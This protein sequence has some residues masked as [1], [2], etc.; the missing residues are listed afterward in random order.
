MAIIEEA[1]RQIDDASFRAAASAAVEHEVEQRREQARSFVTP[2]IDEFKTR[3]SEQRAARK[4][5]LSTK[6]V[7]LQAVSS[8]WPV[9][10]A[11]KLEQICRHTFSLGDEQAKEVR[12]A[13]A[14]YLKERHALVLELLESYLAD[15]D[16]YDAITAS[17]RIADQ[18]EA[19]VA[20]LEE[21]V[22]RQVAKAIAHKIELSLHVPY[23][24]THEAAWRGSSDL[25]KLL[26]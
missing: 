11:S 7:E 12:E 17:K 16:E 4:R 3:L 23:A 1:V 24:L 9:E 6:L 18:S 14:E 13:S 15:D 19:L 20:R 21:H 10:K 25:E 5:K 2:I 26:P 22:E 8:E